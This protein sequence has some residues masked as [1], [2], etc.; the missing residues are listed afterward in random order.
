MSKVK[1]LLA[2]MEEIGLI[3][4]A[5][6]LTDWCAGMV[7]VPKPDKDEV[8]ICVDLTKLN[9]SVKRERHMLPSAKHTLGVLECAK[10]FS[11]LNANSTFHN[12]PHYLWEVLV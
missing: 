8:R 4:K 10:V 12:I 3:S 6:Q 11:K 5:E 9:E 1:K 7:T 2:R